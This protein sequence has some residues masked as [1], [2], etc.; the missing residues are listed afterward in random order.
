MCLDQSCVRENTWW[1]HSYIHHEATTPSRVGRDRRRSAVSR[2][3]SCWER[4]PS[5]L[6]GLGLA[7]ARGKLSAL[8]QPREAV[9]TAGGKATNPCVV[10]RDAIRRR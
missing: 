2:I 10:S 4:N 1:T 7:Q 6:D 5:S 8:D 9:L 3:S